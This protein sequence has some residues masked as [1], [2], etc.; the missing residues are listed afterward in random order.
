MSPLA[1]APA[2]SQITAVFGLPIYLD[3]SMM[4]FALI[5]IL[6]IGYAVLDG[7]DLGVGTL[8]LFARTDQD[9]RIILN[10]IGPIWDGNEVWLVTGGGALFAAFPLVYASIF[11]GFYLA[12]MVLLVALIFRA[13]AIEFRSKE[14]WP[15]WR[16]FWDTSFSISSTACG[17][18]L[19]VVLGNLAQGLPLNEQGFIRIGFFQLLTPYPLLVGLLTVALFAMHGANYL[20]LKT[21]GTLY[22]NVRA[23]SQT[24]IVI[25]ILLYVMVTGYTL[26]YLPHLVAPFRAF[27][28][29]TL[30]PLATLLIIANIPREYHHHR[31]ML[32]FASS[33]G[34]IVMLLLLFGLG[35]FPNL[36]YASPAG[37]LNLTIYNACSTPKTLSI[38]LLIA[39]LGMPIVGA[40]TISVY[41]IFRGKVK[42]D[43]TSY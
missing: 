6:F 43:T 27:P 8:H 18:L 31:P 41:W 26:L 19:G 20:A 14:P 3:L 30:L 4:W 10:S 29:L 33:S 17:F 21:E 40:Y 7:F 9:R 11:S 25:F 2:S 39:L 32:A 1:L 38:M 15:W 34:A 5:G 16:A 28:I 36:V 12:C 35:M 24:T 37:P 23:W 22:A 13:V 42:L